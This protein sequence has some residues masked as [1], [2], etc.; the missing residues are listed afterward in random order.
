[1]DIRFKKTHP[2]AKLPMRGSLGAAG[3]E[4]YAVSKNEL[5]GGL[6]SYDIGL[7]LEIPHGY[8]GLIFPRSSIFRSGLII[9]NAV[10]VIDEDYRGPI[11][12]IFKRMTEYPLL[13][14]YEVGDRICQLVVI[15]YEALDFV[16]TDELSD[17]DRG[18]RGYGSTGRK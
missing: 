5:F 14:E 12:I 17:T 15:K 8:V 16:E 6:I 10:S 11:K 3:Y 13:R 1:M 18:S 7:A 9:T 2:D 4:L